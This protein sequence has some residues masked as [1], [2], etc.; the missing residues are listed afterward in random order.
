MYALSFRQIASFT[1]RLSTQ[2][3]ILHPLDPP[4]ILSLRWNVAR[5]QCPRHTSQS[6]G[7][8]TMEALIPHIQEYMFFSLIAQTFTAV[9]LVLVWLQLKKK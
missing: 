2:I 4:A 9:M 1:S 8:R 5:L 6:K 3:Q 7:S